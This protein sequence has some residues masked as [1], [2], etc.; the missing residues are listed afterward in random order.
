MTIIYKEITTY[1][2]S[3]SCPADLKE[4]LLITRNEIADNIHHFNSG[5]D[6]E[7]MPI[8]FESIELS[9]QKEETKPKKKA[10]PATKADIKE[11][12]IKDEIL[13]HIKHVPVKPIKHSFTCRI[14]DWLTSP[15]G[16]SWK[17]TK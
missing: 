17:D 3:E 6:L 15:I 11:S 2:K 5:Q 9:T 4:Q 10:P 1:I 13:E 8:V 12:E 7:S 16:R 14:W